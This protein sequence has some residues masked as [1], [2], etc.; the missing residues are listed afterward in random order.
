MPK[1]HTGAAQ[2]AAIVLGRPPANV[3]FQEEGANVDVNLRLRSGH[4]SLD[5]SDISA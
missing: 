1:K 2:Q 5:W 4:V 3:W